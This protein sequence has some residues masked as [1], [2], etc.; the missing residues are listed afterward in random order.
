MKT[1][2]SGNS[3]SDTKAPIGWS[4][5]FS[6]AIFPLLLLILGVIGVSST[7]IFIKFAVRELSIEAILFDNL[8]ITTIAFASGNW[9]S[10]L[11]QSRRGEKTKTITLGEQTSPSGGMIVVWM[12]SLVILNLTGRSLFMWSMTQTRAV[13]GLM[14]SELT[15]VFTFLGGWLFLRKQF[16]RRFAVGL[17][18]AVLGALL[19]TLEDWL[20]PE[21][22][23]FGAMAIVGDGAALMC[24]MFH[25]VGMLLVEKLRQ[26]LSTIRFLTWRSVTGLVFVAP[27]SFALTGMK[28]C[29]LDQV[30]STQ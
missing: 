1:K 19:L 22:Q 16:D 14:L 13:N 8:L 26:H 17:G 6:A 11:W 7:A 25:A 5:L 23:L 3:L 29:D 21:E 18:I 24:A 15:P 10:Q 9:V 12:I 27:R 30:S 20:Q 28:K 4:R 2:A